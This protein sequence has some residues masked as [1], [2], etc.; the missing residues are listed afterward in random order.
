M[1][2]LAQSEFELRFTVPLYH[3]VCIFAIYKVLMVVRC[4]VHFTV[5]YLYRVEALLFSLPVIPVMLVFML[6]C[7]GYRN[8]GSTNYIGKGPTFKTSSAP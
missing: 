5:L 7:F 2:S 1:S 3:A 6:V 8:V 4:P